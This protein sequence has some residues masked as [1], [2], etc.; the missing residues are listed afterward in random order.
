MKKKV[1]VVASTSD[2]LRTFHIPY[3]EKLKET[4]DVFTM[5]KDTNEKFADF[6]I[7]FQKKILSF[8]NFKIIGEIKKILKQEQFDV[9]FLN[10]SLAAF[11]VRMA[12]KGLKNKPR[13]VNIVHGYLFGEKTN[14]CKK[15]AFLSAEKFVRKQTTNIVVMNDEDYDI[16]KDNKLCTGEVYKI[17]GMGINGNRFSKKPIKNTGLE[18]EI[19]FSFIGELSSRKNQSFLIE[20]V[21]ELEKFGINAKLNLLG[22]GAQKEKLEKKIKRLGLQNKVKLIGFVDDIEKFINKSN[23]Y[24]C[25]SKIE[26]LPFNILEAM[27]AGSVIFSSDIKGTVDLIKD[28]E[29]GVLFELGNMSDLVNKFRLVKNNL[30]LQEKLRKNAKKTAEKYLL[31]EVFDENMKLF[32]KLVNEE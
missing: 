13:V 15:M 21:K 2:H 4:C 26:G 1:L 29:N 7:N 16:V 25:A 5:S 28:F 11:F 17:Q 22:E 18:E 32:E 10:T 19:N 23:Y 9:V 30:T 20:F 24:I 31:S 27:F 8:K 3:I 6:N 12:I 14:Y